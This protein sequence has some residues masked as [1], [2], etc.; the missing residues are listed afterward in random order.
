MLDAPA[1]R[2]EEMAAGDI[3][4]TA[5]Q[6]QGAAPM[7]GMVRGHPPPTRRCDQARVDCREREPV[8]GQRKGPSRCPP[9]RRSR[10]ARA[11][12]STSRTTARQSLVGRELEVRL[13]VRRARPRPRRAS[14]QLVTLVGV[15]GM[16]KSRLVWRAVP[17][18]RVGARVHPLAPG[19]GALLRRAASLRGAR[20]RW[21]RSQVGVL[22]T[23]SADAGGGEAARG[24]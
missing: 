5:S 17:A 4:N 23:D 16:G 11:S 20:A 19:A 21:C 14:L 18:N 1:A 22:E 12:A 24:A 3:V 8:Q 6:I 10:R 13:L 7:T 9:G 2:G 15:P